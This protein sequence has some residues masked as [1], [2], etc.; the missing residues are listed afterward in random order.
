[1]KKT[2][3]RKR[4]GVKLAVVVC[5]LVMLLTGCTSASTIESKSFDVDGA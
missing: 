1:M 5:T 3:F 2:V 4:Y